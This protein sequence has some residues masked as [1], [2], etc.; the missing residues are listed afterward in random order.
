MHW[1]AAAVAW[2][3]VHV[4]NDGAHLTLTASKP[5]SWQ[6][7]HALVEQQQRSWRLTQR[8]RLA[9]VEALGSPLQAHQLE[10]LLH[11]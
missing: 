4:M 10:Q 6:P 9:E 8:E 3:W 7:Q 5:S 11:A 2:R 1:D